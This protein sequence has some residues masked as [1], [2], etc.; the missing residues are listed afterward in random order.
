M[1][2]SHIPIVNK[3][4]TP[5]AEEIEFYRGLIEALKEAEKEGLQQLFIKETW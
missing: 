5:T 1:H 3:V 2:P 4:F